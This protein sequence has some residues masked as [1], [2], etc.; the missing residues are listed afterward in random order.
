VREIE[1]KRVK[2]MLLRKKKEKKKKKKE[3]VNKERKWSIKERV[4]RNNKCISNELAM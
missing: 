4:F 3:T 2:E 1:K